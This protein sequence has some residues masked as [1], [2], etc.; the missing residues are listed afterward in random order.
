MNILS[1]NWAT[2][3]KVGTVGVC[4]VILIVGYKIFQVFI[5][6]WKN[7]TEAVNKN[8]SAFTE[9]SRVF[10]RANERE[11][12]WQERAMDI[13]KETNKKVKDIHDKVV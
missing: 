11:I 2:L 10:E 12:D 3:D 6:Q 13:M 4:V 1:F 9:L 8:T 5:D 7:S